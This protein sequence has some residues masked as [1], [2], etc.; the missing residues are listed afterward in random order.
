[1]NGTCYL[2]DFS[3]LLY[4][5]TYFPYDSPA[6]NTPRV[7]PHSTI[8]FPYHIKGVHIFCDFPVLSCQ[9][10]VMTLIYLL[11]LYQGYLLSPWVLCP[12]MWPSLFLLL[13]HVLDS[14]CMISNPGHRPGHSSKNLNA[15]YL[16]K[17]ISETMRSLLGI[18]TALW[19]TLSI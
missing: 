17:K 5:S 8:S 7:H 14:S 10:Y 2:S 13:H 11:W 1:M 6:P 9:E 18:L 16:E 3:L 12:T 15:L 4:H 19:S